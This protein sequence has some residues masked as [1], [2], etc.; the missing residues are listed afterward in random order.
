MTDA[1]RQS[2]TLLGIAGD[3]AGRLISALPSQFL[4]LV[5]MNTVFIVGLLWFVMKQDDARERI[6]APILQT[7]MKQVPLEVLQE[8]RKLPP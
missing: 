4:V 8:L 2:G 3:T 5:L 6:Y 7:C 1:E